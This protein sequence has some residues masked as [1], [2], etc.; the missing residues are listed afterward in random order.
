MYSWAICQN[1]SG[2][3]SNDTLNS[4]F[5]HFCRTWYFTVLSATGGGGFVV[6]YSTSRF[7]V[8][9]LVHFKLIFV[10]D[11][12]YESDF[13]LLQVDQVLLAQFVE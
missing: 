10:Q 7:Q 4:F 12:R 13:I 8:K 2:C 1:S 9:I 3:G 11:K 5:F 6:S